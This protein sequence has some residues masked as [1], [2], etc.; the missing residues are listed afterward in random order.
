M[1]KL[2][3]DPNRSSRLMGVF[4][5]NADFTQVPDDLVD[6]ATQ[7]PK[8]AGVQFVAFLKNRCS[9]IVGEPKII[10][11]DRST[12][13]NPAFVGGGFRIDEEDKNSLKL[14]EVNLSKVSLE[15]MLEEGETRVNGEEKLKRLKK[16]KHIR[17]DA[18]VFQTLWENQ[19][20]IPASWKEKTNG[21]TTYIFFDGTVLRDSDGDRYV[22]YLYWFGDRWDWDGRWLGRDWRASLPSAVVAS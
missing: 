22:L 12:P 9:L 13:F 19:E 17:L 8:Q 1:R 15:T 20:L 2:I 11:I 14:T 3:T 4:Q 21:N 10:P 18:K 6:W 5:T 7:N 16:A